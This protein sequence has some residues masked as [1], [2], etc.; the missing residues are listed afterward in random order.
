MPV[1]AQARHARG[2]RDS[3]FV[4]RDSD[5][6]FIYVRPFKKADQTSASM[7]DRRDRVRLTTGFTSRI[8]NYQRKNKSDLFVQPPAA[9]RT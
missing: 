2:I 4:I 5:L 1:E 9:I 8:T 3:G 6:L 7:T